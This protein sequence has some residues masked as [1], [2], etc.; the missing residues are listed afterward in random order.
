MP[1]QS[2]EIS[3][4]THQPGICPAAEKTSCLSDVSI[5]RVRDL[6][7][8]TYRNGRGR[9]HVLTVSTSGVH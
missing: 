6:P 8:I 1:T 2:I 3:V 4:H 9:F 5:P 7:S